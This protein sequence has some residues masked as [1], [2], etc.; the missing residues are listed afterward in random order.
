MSLIDSQNEFSDGQTLAMAV[1]DH[2]STNLVDLSLARNIGIGE[3]VPLTVQ[4]T[5]D[6][7]SG[8][9]GTLQILVES[10]ADVAFGSP[11]VLYT[12]AAIALG[13]LVAGYKFPISFVPRVNEQHI[14]I[15]YRVGTA[16]LTG[17][18]VDANIG[19]EDQT[20]LVNV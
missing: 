14:R 18:T 4:I 19:S 12:S 20:N 1:G 15:L 3:P 16:D 8:G 17:G 10:D 11:S 5:D 6:A 13:T 2:A 7:T 9:A